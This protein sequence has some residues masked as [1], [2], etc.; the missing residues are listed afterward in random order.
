[1]TSVAKEPSELLQHFFGF[2]SFRPGQE[3]VINHLL[4]GHSAAAV[5]PTGGGK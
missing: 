4:Q 5:F 3:T 2:D 1:M